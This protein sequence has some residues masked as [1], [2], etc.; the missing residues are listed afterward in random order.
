MYTSCEPCPMCLGAIYWSR[1]HSVYYAANRKD[2]ASLHFDDDFIY[3][4]INLLPGE[5]S[6]PFIQLPVISALDPIHSW[7]SLANKTIY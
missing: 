4:E 6:L 7:S 1:I 2:A 3:D 5:R